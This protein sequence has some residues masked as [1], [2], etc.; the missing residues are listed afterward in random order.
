[1]DV[2]D[3]FDETLLGLRKYGFSFLTG[4]ITAS[5]FLG[6]SNVVNNSLVQIAIIVV[7]MILVVVLYWLDIYYQNVL[8]GAILRSQ[9]L[10]TFRLN[11]RLSSYISSYYSNSSV[12][13]MLHWL[14]L[15]FLVGLLVLG[16]YVLDTANLTG[17]F[18]V[19]LLAAFFISLF[20]VIGIWLK[21]DRKRYHKYDKVTKLYENLKGKVRAKQISADEAEEEVT[22]LLSVE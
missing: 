12:G 16:F 9:F 8:T 3:K 5:S 7:T 10:G 11:M 17:K 6:L 1:M 14:Y 18:G 2:I 20:I 19:S 4:L 21:W 13:S 22:E 15:G